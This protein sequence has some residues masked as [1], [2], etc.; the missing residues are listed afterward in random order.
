MSMIFTNLDMR[1]HTCTLCASLDPDNPHPPG[2]SVFDQL[3][4]LVI[5]HSA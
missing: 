5:D 2:G 3:Q 4:S 1:A